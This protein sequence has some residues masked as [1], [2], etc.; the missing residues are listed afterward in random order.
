[1]KNIKT[2][3]QE[4]GF[5]ML[6]IVLAIVVIAIA[7]FG[8]Y[9]LYNS[10]NMNS[11]LSSEEDLVSQIY[12]QATQMSFSNSAQPTATELFNSGA[13]S[14]DVWPNATA[15]FNAAFGAVTYDCDT[16]DIPKWSSITASNIPSS[17]AGEFTA[18]M[19]SWGDVYVDGT[20]YD[21]SK[22]AFT[23]KTSYEITV[24]FPQGNK[25]NDSGDNT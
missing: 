6:E 24:Y 19:L 7:S 17:V 12:N 13:F 11:K 23:D 3:K 1:M 4:S 5:A 8:I 2:I 9:K 22:T 16:A 14:T 21:A 25:T 18:H 10:A 15:N 20:P